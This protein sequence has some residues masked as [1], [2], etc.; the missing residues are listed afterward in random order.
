MLN[1]F[2]LEVI[3]LVATQRDH[4]MIIAA[5]FYDLRRQNNF[6]GR[7]LRV[8]LPTLGLRRGD[9]LE[10]C[11]GLTDMHRFEEL[12]VPFTVIFWRTSIATRLWRMSPLWIIPGFGLQCLSIDLL[13]TLDLGTL[14]ALDNAMVART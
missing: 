10:P 9:R 1:R 2:E 13:H 8:D 12:V 11:E 5:L 4:D 3:L 14:R 6:G 7:A